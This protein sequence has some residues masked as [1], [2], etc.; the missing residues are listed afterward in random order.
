MAN[1][2][3]NKDA[4]NSALPQPSEDI[5]NMTHKPPTFNSNCKYHQI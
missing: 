1:P 2:V 3:I 4:N 5:L